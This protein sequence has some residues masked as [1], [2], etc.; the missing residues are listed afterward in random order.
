MALKPSFEHYPR[1]IRQA[2]VAAIGLRNRRRRFGS[3]YR[4]WSE[5]LSSTTCPS[6]IQIQE[7]Q[8]ARLRKL[9]ASASSGSPYYKEIETRGFDNVRELRAALDT[10]PL[11]T[12]NELRN[13]PRDL[14]NA[15]VRP[16]VRT[17]TSGS[18][19]APVTIEHDGASIQRRFAFFHD[20]LRMAGVEPE[21]ASVRFSGRIICAVGKPDSKPWLM[22]Y[23]ENQAFYSTYHLG[24]ANRGAIER[25]FNH[26]KPVLLDGY[27]SAIIDALRLLRDAPG[28]RSTIRA[29]ITT[30]ETLD[31]SLRSS[32]ESL[33]GAPV[34]DYYSASEG[35]PFIQQCTKGTYHV[36][37]Q[38]GI[39][40]VDSGDAI[41]F[42]GSGELICTSFVQDRV[43][44]LRYRTGDLVQ[45]LTSVPTLC[46]CGLAT[47]TVEAVLGRVEDRVYTPDGRAI[48]M[49]TYRTLKHI[50]GIGESSVVQKSF[51]QFLVYTVLKEKQS[52]EEISTEIHRS[53]ERALGYEIRPVTVVSVDS[54]PRGAN[55]K[56][57]LVTTHVR[58]VGRS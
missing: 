22:N 46:G 36:R 15:N 23:A 27:P 32:I 19:G 44:L 42:D 34:M 45:G 1:P 25:L 3:E 41:G 4:A 33:A 13:R 57:R 52:V 12:K 9:V 5:L 16:L 2:V 30:A 47:P 20:H 24:D 39:F 35:L 17:S 51:D 53:F 14:A 29:V 40:E 43:P 6:E 21:E 55:G 37:W 58:P 10:L 31:P 28:A 54:L 38:S 56:I 49:F 7:W 11:L 50:S 18:T 26:H 8:I 48:G